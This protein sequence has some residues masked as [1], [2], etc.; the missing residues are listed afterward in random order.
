MGAAGGVK[1]SLESDGPALPTPEATMD[2][3]T[4]SAVATPTTEAAAA[5]S[6][7]AKPVAFVVSTPIAACAAVRMARSAVA[8]QN[9][10]VART[11]MSVTFHGRFFGS[12]PERMISATNGRTVS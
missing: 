12:L 3:R 8:P 7:S 6:M 10:A 1:T 11:L 4:D 2:V 5:Q 9:A